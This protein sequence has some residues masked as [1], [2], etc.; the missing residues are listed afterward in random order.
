MGA[1]DTTTR[2]HGVEALLDGEVL[3]DALIRE[4]GD[5]AS[6]AAEPS[7]DVHATAAYR[8]HVTGSLVRKALRQMQAQT[9]VAR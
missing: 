8:A 9:E 6:N 2:L 4:A 3:D 5:A 1:G 7:S